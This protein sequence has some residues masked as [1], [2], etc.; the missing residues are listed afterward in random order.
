MGRECGAGGGGVLVTRGHVPQ[1]LDHGQLGRQ[2]RRRGVHGRLRRDGA[3]ETAELQRSS[4][5]RPTCP[6]GGSTRRGRP[7]WR[8]A[9]YTSMPSDNYANNAASPSNYSFTC[10]TP[11]PSGTNN[12]T[13]DPA[14]V[15]RSAADLRLA[16]NSP[17]IDAGIN[18]DWMFGATDLRNPRVLNARVDMGAYETPFTLNLR[19]CCKALTA[20][21][22]TRHDRPSNPENIST[23]SP[24]APDPRKVPTIPLQRRGLGAD[25]AMSTN[26][27]TAIRE[28]RVSEHTR[29]DSSPPTGDP[30]SRRR[31][32][33][34]LLLH[35]GQAPQSSGGDVGPACG[36]HEL[37]CRLR[38]HDGRR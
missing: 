6:A 21:I 1:L 13:G 31:D 22:P 20:Q 27:N 36:V 3:R 24:Y 5:T 17:C 8:T 15:D 19:A 30:G 37:S 29:A 14:F 28:E 9:S 23:T 2:L 34:R 10:T 38:L 26:G 16:A 33:R 35:R 18:Q 7:T 11:L 32:F 12:I 25:R 4:T